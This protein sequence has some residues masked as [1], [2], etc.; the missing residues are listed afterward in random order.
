MFQSINISES[1]TVF[2]YVD[3]RAFVRDRIDWLKQLDSTF[4]FRKFSKKIGFASHGHIHLIL[5]GR[6][7]LAEKS[8]LKL[9][10]GFDLN[11]L[12]TKAFLEL[13]RLEKISDDSAKNQM[14]QK[15]IADRMRRK[16]KKLEEHQFDYFSNWYYPVIREIVGLSEFKLDTR[17]IADKLMGRVTPAEVSQALKTLLA[18]Q[19]IRSEGNHLVQSEPTVQTNDINP[20]SEL[21]NG[22]HRAMMAQAAEAQEIVPDSL[23]EISGMTLT[24]DPDDFAQLK[25][26]L[27]AFRDAIF[28]R[29]GQ[30]KSNHTSVCQVNFQLF[31]LT[32]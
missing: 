29:Y 25:S 6:A 10:Q 12:E 9:A 5:S 1:P 21:L 19:M 26:E 17:W 31:P 15:L 27:L 18:L 32:K 3:Y 28:Q 7:E 11:K 16:K 20:Y 24:V 2:D 23:R 13:V 14:R 22:F 30:V 8:A 4:S